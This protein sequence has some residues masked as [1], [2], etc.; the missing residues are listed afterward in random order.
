MVLL[1]VNDDDSVVMVFCGTDSFT[2][3]LT[4]VQFIRE[5]IFEGQPY[6]AHTGFLDAFKKVYKSISAHV[7]PF[8][9]KKKIYTAGH[10]LGGALA[11]LL[12][13]CISHKYENVKLIHRCPPVGNTT[14]SQ[15]FKEMHSHII[16]IQNN[17]VKTGRLINLMATYGLFQP[18]QVMFLP[19]VGGH[20]ILEY[21]KQLENLSK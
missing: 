21:I 6:L 10:S 11:S 13:L 15:Y 2:N 4:D 14:L 1:L 7:K 12:A 9:G 3:A 8:I 17:P 18:H 16:T 5:P 19:A 20:S